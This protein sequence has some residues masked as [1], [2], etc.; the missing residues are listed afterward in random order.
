MPGDAEP[1]LTSSV[2]TADPALGAT[3]DGFNEPVRPEGADAVRPTASLK[4]FRS[5]IVIA[6]VALAPA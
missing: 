4:P 3:I 2:E 1:D 5:S 6:E